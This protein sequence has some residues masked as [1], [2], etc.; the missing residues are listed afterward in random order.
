MSD[1]FRIVRIDGKGLGCIAT[2]DI[3]RGTLILNETPQLKCTMKGGWIP[4]LKIAYDRMS[5]S[6]KLDFM[7]LHDSYIDELPKST[8]LEFQQNAKKWI[9]FHYGGHERSA[10]VKVVMKIISVF[11][12]NERHSDIFDEI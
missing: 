8:I 12:S 1:I 4:K 7:A 11:L 5:I 3:P 6:E 9:C 2:K 10:F